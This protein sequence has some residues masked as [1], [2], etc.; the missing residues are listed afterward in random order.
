[1]IKILY[2]VEKSMKNFLINYIKMQQYIYKSIGDN[3]K[4]KDRKEL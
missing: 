2:K 4:I 3:I 1:M